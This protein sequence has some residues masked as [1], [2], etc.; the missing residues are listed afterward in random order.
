VTCSGD[1]FK[2]SWELD[3]YT[4]M[5]RKLCIQV[6]TWV[7]AVVKAIKSLRATYLT[8]SGSA[9]DAA[10]TFLD[11]YLMTITTVRAFV[12][13]CHIPSETGNVFQVGKRYRLTSDHAQIFSLFTY[14]GNRQ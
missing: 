13:V 14:F 10:I 8:T 3:G 2:T 6:K 5:I 7:N 4:T 12:G 11:R 9:Y 1:L